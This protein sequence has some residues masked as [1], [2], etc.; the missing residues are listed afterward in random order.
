MEK[1]ENKTPFSTKFYIAGVLVFGLIAISS[2]I[3]SF[4]YSDSGTSRSSQSSS[5]GS[6]KAAS[7]F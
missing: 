3:L 2:G 5:V 1:S 4:I 6:S 7:P